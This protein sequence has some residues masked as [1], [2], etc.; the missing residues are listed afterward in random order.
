MSLLLTDDKEIA[1]LNSKIQALMTATGQKSTSFQHAVQELNNLEVHV[2]PYLREEVNKFCGQI[3]PALKS[4]IEQLRASAFNLEE[5][6]NELK[7]QLLHIQQSHK[8]LSEHN[9]KASKLP[10]QF[11]STI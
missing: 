11:D 8:G 7:A 2:P 3:L 5:K 4:L 1:E 6:R 9:V 10:K